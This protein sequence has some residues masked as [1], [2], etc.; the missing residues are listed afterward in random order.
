MKKL[1]LALALLAAGGAAQAQ[2]AVTVYGNIAECR[3]DPFV[4]GRGFGAA[5]VNFYGVGIHHRF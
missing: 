1:F 5:K 4:V 3:R 2:S